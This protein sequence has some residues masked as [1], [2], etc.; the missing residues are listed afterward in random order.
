MS[1]SVKSLFK[2]ATTATAPGPFVVLRFNGIQEELD[3]FANQLSL[4][5]ETPVLDILSIS[6][7]GHY[8]DS[9]VYVG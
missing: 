9:L 5:S 7:A 2:L 6:L 8:A 3:H 1:R 4:S